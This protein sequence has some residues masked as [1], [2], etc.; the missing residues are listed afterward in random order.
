MKSA[1]GA[2]ATGADA[3]AAADVDA[4]GGASAGADAHADAG[5]DAGQGLELATLEDGAMDV[6]CGGGASKDEEGALPLDGASGSGGGDGGGSIVAGKKADVGLE[7]TALE[8]STESEEPSLCRKQMTCV[9]NFMLEPLN[10]AL[11]VGLIVGLIKPLQEGL[12]DKESDSVLRVVGGTIE[13]LASPVVGLLMLTTGAAL[14]HV[15]LSKLQQLDSA[16]SKKRN[17]DAEEAAA[18]AAA[19]AG[20]AAPT[21]TVMGA[22]RAVRHIIAGFTLSRLVAAPLVLICLFYIAPGLRPASD[23]TQLVALVASAMP[24]AQILVMLLNKL[25]MPS[26]ASELVFLFIFQYSASILTTGAVVVIALGMVYG[27]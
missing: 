2:E 5:A 8:E 27:Q 24:C 7:G 10:F 26:S 17:A 16:A 6:L 12:F 15:D 9:C 23:L 22:A 21:I 4:G 11:I 25:G 14:A 13:L 20:A 19:A 18:A 3:D 1:A